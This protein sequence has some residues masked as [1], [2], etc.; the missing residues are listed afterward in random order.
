MTQYT[1]T[2]LE[3]WT[4]EKSTR[5]IHPDA[6]LIDERDYGGGEYC[7]KYECPNCGLIFEVELP[8]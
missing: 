6:E 3:P 2:A 4:P 1:C 8:Q 7:E 5:A